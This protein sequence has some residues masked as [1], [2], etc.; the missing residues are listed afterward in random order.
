MGKQWGNSDRLYFWGFQNHCRGDCSHEIKIFLLLGRKVMTNLDS[1]LKSRDITANKIPSSQS[2][3]FSSSHVWKWVLDYRESWALKN[4]CFWNVVLEK[5]LQIPLDCKEIKP[6]KTKGNQ[7]WILIWRIDAE[8]EVPILWP[9]DAESTHWKRAW[10]WERLKARK[11]R[12]RQ[13]IR[14]LDGITDATDMSLNRF[15]ELMMEPSLGP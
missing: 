12:G 8:A 11:K 3:D 5:T 14:W 10:C 13:R 15:Q 9:S 7:S 4:W 2:C 6:V 1:I